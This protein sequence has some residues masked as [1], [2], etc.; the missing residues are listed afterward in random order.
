METLNYPDNP[1]K[2]DYQ[3]IEN[4]K[5]KRY[6]TMKIFSMCLKSRLAKDLIPIL[7]PRQTF[8]AIEI[9]S[10]NLV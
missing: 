7:L 1:R 2:N 9:V 6:Y 10:T 8:G 4:E 5:L 3:P